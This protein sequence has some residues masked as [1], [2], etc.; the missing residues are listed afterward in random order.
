M[1]CNKGQQIKRIIFL[2]V[3]I[4]SFQ[5]STAQ[6]FETTT[7]YKVIPNF[8]DKGSEYLNTTFKIVD[9][10]EE[11]ESFSTFTIKDEESYEEM[12]IT[13]LKNPGLQ[14]I[15]EVVKVE[16]ESTTCCTAVEAYYFLVAEDKNF[17]SLPSLENVYCENSGQ[18]IHYIF[19]NQAFGNEGSILK[20]KMSYTK[21]YDVQQVNVLQQFSWNED[22]HEDD[23]LVAYHTEY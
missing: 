6:N 2:L 13:V 23:H 20:T 12:N 17:T 1:K 4:F 5:L 8:K 10:Q 11:S 18:D 7:K 14:G 19:P 9:A 15:T 16:V 3:A 21:T 22:N